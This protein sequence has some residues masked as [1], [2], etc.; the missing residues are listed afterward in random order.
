MSKYICELALKDGWTVYCT[1]RNSDKRFLVEELEW[2]Y[3]DYQFYES[4]DGALA[5]LQKIELTKVIYLSGELSNLQNEDPEIDEIEDYLKRN[6][7]M[8][9]WFLKSFLVHN[10]FKE[11]STFTYLS[12]RSSDFGS[13]DYYYGIA[14]AALENLI[15]SVSLLSV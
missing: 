15:K 7:L 5:I 4:L 2:I 3:L 1:Y 11:G 14:K 8:P 13:N 9:I 12:S 6:I 10:V